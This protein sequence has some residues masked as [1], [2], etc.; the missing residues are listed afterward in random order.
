[1]AMVLV[2]TYSFSN[3]NSGVNI[4]QAMGKRNLN[5]LIQNLNC[6][7]LGNRSIHDATEVSHLPDPRNYNALDKLPQEFLGEGRQRI[8]AVTKYIVTL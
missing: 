8:G 6:L 3:T 2:Q 5:A 7:N 4:D 1:M